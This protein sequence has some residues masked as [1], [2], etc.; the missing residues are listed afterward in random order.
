V[1]SIAI[2]LGFILLL[3][4]S[5]MADQVRVGYPG[6]TYGPYQTGSGG[7][8]TLTPVT[9][10]LDL[11]HYDAVARN[12][13]GSSGSFQT[14][15]LEG[16]ELIS[17]YNHTY[18]A[19]INQNAVWGGIGPAGDPLS[20]GTGW[21]YSMFA[22]NNWESDLKYNYPG[23]ISRKADAGLLQNAIWWLE[24]EEGILYEAK[25]NKFMD[26]A[27]AR[28]GSQDGAKADGG[29]LFGVY[30]L[31]L[32]TANGGRVQDQVY[33]KGIPVPE[34]GSTLLFLAMAFV[35]LALSY[36]WWQ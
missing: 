14:F 23:L 15:C 13:G 18:N 16:S 30:A 5:A 28:F 35:P 12:A 36:R 4:S 7:E 19:D 24:G 2:I 20:I 33:F 22:S 21:L 10:W 9:G 11:S 25:K 1:K 8:F 32:T 27:V 29:W 34:A 17:G 31:N 26:A 3:A 6:S